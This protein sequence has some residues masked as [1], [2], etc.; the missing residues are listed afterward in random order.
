MR[1]N[2][3]IGRIGGEEFALALPGASDSA[4]YVIADRIREAFAKV[5]RTVEGR[6]VHA[7]VSAGVA[8]AHPASTLDGLLRTADEQLYMAKSQGRNRVRRAGRPEGGGKTG[9]VIRVA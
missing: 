4:A 5:A 6:E 2:D 1:A 9:T 8:T 3:M 7:T